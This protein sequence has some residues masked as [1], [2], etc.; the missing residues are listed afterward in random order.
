[1]RTQD[2][3]LSSLS[4]LALEWPHYNTHTEMVKQN[5]N[6]CLIE[7]TV[8]EIWNRFWIFLFLPINWRGAHFAILNVA[9]PW[10]C[11]TLYAHNNNSYY[12]TTL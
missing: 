8:L 2:N 4:R 3:E 11:T 9:Q 10:F 5:Q 12:W 6:A 7:F 1:V